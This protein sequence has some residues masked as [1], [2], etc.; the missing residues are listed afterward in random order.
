MRPEE[1]LKDLGYEL[2]ELPVPIGV[3]IPYAEYNGLIFLS[4]LLPVKDGRLLYQGRIGKDLSIEQAKECTVQ[5]VLN[6]LSIIKSNLGDLEKID[7]CLRI[8][9]YLQTSEDFKDHPLVLNAASELI[10]KVFGDR[11]RHTR[12]AIGAHTLPMNSPVEMDF[13]FSLRGLARQS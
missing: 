1:I 11:G 7:R 10:V 5:I 12:I 8:N 13:I 9:G 2:P 6:C 4:G 3:Y